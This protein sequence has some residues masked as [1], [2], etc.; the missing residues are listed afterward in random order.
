MFPVSPLDDLAEELARKF[1]GQILS[2]FTELYSRS[3][4]P[5]FGQAEH[6][7]ALRILERKG[8]LSVVSYSAKRT[9]RDGELSIPLNAILMFK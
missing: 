3:N 6:K 7:K 2:G 9:E 8:L 5:R 4:H 1:G